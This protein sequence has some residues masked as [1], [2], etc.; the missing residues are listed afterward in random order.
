MGTAKIPAEMTGPE[1]AGLLGCGPRMVRSLA[2]RGLVKRA[3]HGRYEVAASI[4]TY[5]G[6]LREQAAG[7]I[8]H[9]PSIDIVRENALLRRAK[10]RMLEI[11][12]E[13]LSGSLISLEEVK[14]LWSCIVVNVRTI[15]LAIPSRARE[16]LPHLSRLDL[17]TLD[18]ICR[19]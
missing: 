4:K 10:R 8:G 3:R 19:E 18:D 5:V 6:H 12:H 17:N 13:R 14:E 15:A 16:A 1:L 11:K 7:R 9:D 2:G